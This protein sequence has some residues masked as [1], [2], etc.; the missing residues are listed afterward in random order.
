M[1]DINAMAVSMLPRPAIDPPVIARAVTP[2]RLA[3]LEAALSRHVGPEVR[4]DLQGIV[5]SYSEGG[6]LKFNGEV[7]DTPE[8]LLAFHLAMGFDREHGVLRGLGAEITHVSYT[9]D[10]VIV[11][12][13]MF[14]TTAVEL[15][16]APAGREIKFPS[17]GVYQFDDGGR[18]ISERIYLDTGC[19]LP[20]PIFRP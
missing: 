11:E 7:Y 3:F 18:L 6:H 20:T 13:A 17:C 19:W 2:E 16:G 12:Y 5:D 14:G 8:R 10:S 1:D 4:G 9:Y 15:A